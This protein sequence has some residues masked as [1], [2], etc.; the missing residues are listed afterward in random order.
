MTGRLDLLLDRACKLRTFGSKGASGQAAI[1]VEGF[2]DAAAPAQLAPGAPQSG[3]LGDLQQRVL[4]RCRFVRP[5]RH[6]GARPRATDLR[7]WRKRRKPASKPQIATIE[8]K[9]GRP[10]TR[11]RLEGKVEPGRYLATAYGGESAVWPEA[12]G[13]PLHDPSSDAGEPLRPAW[14][15]APSVRS[16]PAR[17]LAPLAMDAFRIELKEPAPVR[18]MSAPGRRRRPLVAKNSRD[19]SP[20]RRLPPMARIP[21]SSK[22][23]LEGQAFRLRACTSPATA[24]ASRASR[25]PARLSSLSTWR[26][27]AATKFRRRRCSCA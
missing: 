17:F 12:A 1:R 9:A 5:G 16:V 2:R 19:P 4:D 23:G 22:T 18:M 14:R 24:R 6:R 20:S 25:A 11:V 7:L 27:R 21:R 10:M 26:A 13:A 3:D 8:T 15:K